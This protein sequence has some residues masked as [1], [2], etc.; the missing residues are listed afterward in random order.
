MKKYNLILILTLGFQ[1][2]SLA[3]SIPKENPRRLEVK[4]LKSLIKFKSSINNELLSN[5]KNNKSVLEWIKPYLE[6]RDYM[7]KLYIELYGQ[8]IGSMLFNKNSEKIA[9]KYF[10]PLEI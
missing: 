2:S 5:L 3:I 10:K 6:Y 4:L 7:K 9:E 8:K 1:A